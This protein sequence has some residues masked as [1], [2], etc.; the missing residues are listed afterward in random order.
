MNDKSRTDEFLALLAQHE[1]QIYSFLYALVCHRDDAQDLMQEATVTLWRKFDQFKSGTNFVSWACEISKNCALNFFQA[2]K[3]RKMFSTTMI[4]LLAETESS[5]DVET[6]L[7]RRQALTQCLDKLGAKDR[8]LITECYEHST[9]VKAVAERSNRPV[10]G[11][12][13]SLSR[14]RRAL[15]LCIEATLAREGQPG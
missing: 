4:E 11:I 1:S 8:E 3:R 12:Y 6:R 10:A 15:Y 9:S 5:R 7:A 14:I 2:R 13:N